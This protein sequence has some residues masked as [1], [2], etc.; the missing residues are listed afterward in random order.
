MPET[1]A[2]TS[3]SL[4]PS[5]CPGML[6]RMGTLFGSTL[7]TCTEIGGGAAALGA[8]S[9]PHATSSAAAMMAG[10]QVNGGANSA[11][12]DTGVWRSIGSMCST[13]REKTTGGNRYITAL[14]II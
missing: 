4:E 7:T 2:R 6:K 12:R 14:A 5:T 13:S 11:R 3:T 8:L 9:L 1:R 10:R